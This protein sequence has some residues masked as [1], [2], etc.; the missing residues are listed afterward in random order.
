MICTDNADIRSNDGIISYIYISDPLDV[1]SGRKTRC[2]PDSDENI[3]GIANNTG[4]VRRPICLP[5][6]AKNFLYDPGFYRDGR[7]SPR[8]S[9]NDRN[10]R[11]TAKNIFYE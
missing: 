5:V 9:E 6:K 3:P 4:W 2:G 7:G 10:I 1:T 8:G 11:N